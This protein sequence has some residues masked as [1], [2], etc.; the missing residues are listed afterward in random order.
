MRKVVGKVPHIQGISRQ[1][2]VLLQDSIRL[3]YPEPLIKVTVRAEYVKRGD[4]S[5]FSGPHPAVLDSLREQ[6]H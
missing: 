5:P 4:R 3:K 2:N 1:L 6:S